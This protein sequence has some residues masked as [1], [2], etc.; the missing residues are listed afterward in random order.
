MKPLLLIS[1]MF[2]SALAIYAQDF[3]KILILNGDFTLTNEKGILNWK[4]DSRDWPG[5]LTVETDPDGSKFLSVIPLPSPTQ[6]DNSGKPLSYSM[7]LNTTKFIASKGDVVRVKFKF[8]LSD[9]NKESPASLFVI[10]GSLGSKDSTWF[11]TLRSRNPSVGKWCEYECT[12]ELSRLMGEGEC[13]FI[14]HSRGSKIDYKDFSLE[15]Q[16]K[17]Q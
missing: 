5:K 4:T 10:Y 7:V 9:E 6:K 13:Y 1:V 3:E 17:K 8:R 14:L 12:K 11:A 15:I 2:S 16:R